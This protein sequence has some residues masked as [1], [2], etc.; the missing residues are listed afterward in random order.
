M[1]PTIKDGEKLKIDRNFHKKVSEVERFDIVAFRLSEGQKKYLGLSGE[2]FHYKRIIGL[3]N[4]KLEIKRG[5]VYINDKLLDEPFVKEIWED[6]GFGLITISA[7]EYFVLGDNRPNSA[8][9]RIL[10]PAT[11][12][13]GRYS[14]KSN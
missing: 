13:K 6:N 2:L 10:K 8:D 9:S 11:V 5:H 7:D 12:K 3:P 14:R 4:E 1:S